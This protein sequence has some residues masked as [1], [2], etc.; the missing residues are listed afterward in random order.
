M[1]SKQLLI[2]AFCAILMAAPAARAQTISTDVPKKIDASEKYLFYLHGGIV[3]A[4]GP[5]NAVSEYYGRYEYQKILDALKTKGFHVIAEVRP[6]DTKEDEYAKELKK[7]IKR[8]LKAGVPE[9]NITVVGASL[10]A[11]IAVETAEKL[12][13]KDVKYALLGLCSKYAVGYYAKFKGK[14]RGNFLSIYEDSDEKKSCKEI[15]TPLNRNAQFREIKLEMGNSHAFLY[16]PFDD[17]I[18][19]LVAWSAN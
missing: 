1:I 2:T 3:G 15:F 13:K 18:L 16:E 6:K 8:L 17:W 11:Y 4:K 5:E 19:P 12:R 10:G 7:K 9:E 14:L